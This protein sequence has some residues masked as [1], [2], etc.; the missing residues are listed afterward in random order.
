MSKI[1]ITLLFIC[2]NLPGWA[3]KQNS[4]Q[5]HLV[6][7]FGES[8]KNS[9]LTDNKFYQT[10]KNE[11]ALRETE[12][13]RK[14]A[15]VSVGEFLKKRYCID[16]NLISS[17]S[18]EQT[19]VYMA[20]FGP[21]TKELGKCTEALNDLVKAGPPKKDAKTLM[22]YQKKLTSLIKNIT[23]GFAEICQAEQTLCGCYSG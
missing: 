16:N 12:E 15:E 19:V 5:A 9:A 20:R 3:A 21:Q 6:Y 17:Y 2:T 13:I 18:K 14:A 8:W 11:K 1:I 10:S 4:R 23:A 7:W 22:E